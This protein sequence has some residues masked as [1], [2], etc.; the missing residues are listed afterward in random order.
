[1]IVKQLATIMTKGPNGPVIPVS[2][3]QKAI[4]IIFNEAKELKISFSV[5]GAVVL[6]INKLKRIPFFD[7]MLRE[8]ADGEEYLILILVRSL[9]GL[10]LLGVGDFLLSCR[11]LDLLLI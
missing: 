8:L 3:D 5:R 1:M 11:L 2:C 9:L 7:L 6:G 4:F 10:P